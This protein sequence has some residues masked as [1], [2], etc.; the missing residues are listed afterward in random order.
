MDLCEE[1]PRRRHAAYAY[2]NWA[3][4]LPIRVMDRESGRV[5]C[6]FVLEGNLKLAT[7]EVRSPALR[8][9][10]P[11]ERIEHLSWVERASL[12]AFEFLASIKL[13][14]VLMGW[15]IV[16]LTIGTIVESQVNTA[17]AGY[18]VYRT[19][20]FRILLALLGLCVLCAA[21][22]RFPW[23]R[24]QTGFL[25]THIGLLTLLAGS[26]MS[27]RQGLDSLMPVAQ[28]ST[29]SR[30]YD[31]NFECLFVSVADAHNGFRDRG[32]E[33]QVPVQFGPFTWGHKIFG[34]IPW[35]KDH[36]ETIEL[37]NGDRVRVKMFHANCDPDTTYL[38]AEQGPPAVQ[39]RL[40]NPK[41]GIDNTGWLAADPEAMIGS[42]NMGMGAMLIWRVADQAQLDHFVDGTP[43]V[44]A[45]GLLGTLA[46]SH[47]GKRH[48]LSV[49]QL[50]EK[51]FPVPGSDCTIR[52]IAYLPNAKLDR[53]TNDWT[54]EGDDPKNPLLKLGVKV[55]KDAE[56]TFLSFA[57]R[58]DFD[59]LLVR[60]QGAEHLFT[61]FPADPQPMIEVAV[62][63]D[64]KAGYRAFGSQGLLSVARMEP[65]KEYSGWAG[66]SFTPLKVL[67]SA[68]REGTLRGKSLVRAQPGRPGVVLEYESAGKSARFAIARDDDRPEARELRTKFVGDKMVSIRYGVQE[69]DLPFSIRLDDFEEPKNPGTNQ[70]AMY[71]SKVTLIDKERNKERPQVI[72]MNYPLYH[73]DTN[74]KEYTLY[75]SGI[76][77]STGKPVSTYTVARDPGL[78]TKYVGSILL[79]FGTF[80]MFYMGGYF[81]KS[82]S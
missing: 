25:I 49:S 18:F 47:A 61:Y 27:T 56:K 42:S 60:R 79:V 15:L 59:S 73:T 39:Y 12:R 66:M 51:P 8:K 57:R 50:K 36:S 80:L 33:L 6:R 32:R 26:M 37:E 77:R 28:G 41:R 13:A 1:V 23:R 38:S 44:D 40:A 20:R 74:G 67:G 21:L 19:L 17:A 7:A 35:R 78:K 46:Y 9:A 10:I 68:R 81:K 48:F 64:G 76:D 3:A 4:L 45:S 29:E 71:T 72:T 53:S 22:I 5:S 31:P 54:T 16:E 43:K 30:I 11:I 69:A 2:N 34:S 52:L 70:A 75:Q 58:H 63:P 24:Y 55:G 65:G 14:V 82:S 62:A